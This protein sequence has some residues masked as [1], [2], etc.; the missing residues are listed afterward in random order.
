[1]FTLHPI[2]MDQPRFSFDYPHSPALLDQ[3]YQ[4]DCEAY[5]AHAVDRSIL[6]RWVK[7][8]P[9]SITLILADG[10]IAGAFGLL[11]TSEEQTRK[12][13]A[14]NL[15]ESEFECLPGTIENHRFW[16]WSGV[17]LAKK[18]RLS[19]SSPL[20]KLLS[21]GIDCWLASDRLAKEAY[22]YSSPCTQEGQNLLDRFDFERIKSA[23]EMADSIPLYVRHIKNPHQTRGELRGLLNAKC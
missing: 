21:W 13:I 16:Y 12:F 2:A 19:R 4:L 11:A 8:C 18:Y 17:V 6:E 14:G 15:R 5:G 23:E 20:R 3:L 7:V 10:E 22:V 9:E 1:M